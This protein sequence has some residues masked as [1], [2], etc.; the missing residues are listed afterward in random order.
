MHT[1]YAHGLLFY[2]CSS[3]FVRVPSHTIRVIRV[4]RRP[5]FSFRLCGGL[6]FRSLWPI[7][8]TESDMEAI[9]ESRSAHEREALH[10][11]VSR[12]R[13]ALLSLLP[14]QPVSLAYLYGSAATGRTTPFSDVDI[15]LVVDPGLTPRERLKLVLGLAVDLADHCGL[16]NADVRIINEAPLVFRGRVVTDGIL[17]YARSEGERIDFE[18]AVRAEYFDYLPIHRRLQDAFFADLRERGLYG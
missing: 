13:Q 14:H 15:A 6:P 18:T 3:V 8:G 17:V 16:A 7:I 11:L 2:P 5:E 12:L 10:E 9:Q 1:D 4:H